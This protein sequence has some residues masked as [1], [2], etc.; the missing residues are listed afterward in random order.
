MEEAEQL[1]SRVL[2]LRKEVLGAEHPSILMTVQNLAN[3][4]RARYG[5]DAMG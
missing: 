3:T 5:F 4:P 1:L 2:E